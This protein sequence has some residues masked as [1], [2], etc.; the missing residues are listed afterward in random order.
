MTSSYSAWRSVRKAPTSLYL[1]YGKS[2][3]SN[4]S[5]GE[6]RARVTDRLELEIELSHNLRGRNQ[7][8]N[9]VEDARRL[10]AGDLSDLWE[11]QAERVLLT[12]GER[13]AERQSSSADGLWRLRLHLDGEW[14][15]LA[16][17]ASAEGS[18]LI[19]EIVRREQPV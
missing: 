1:R 2:Y 4:L 19:L 5:A 9:T 14:V 8:T 18:G 7:S 3:T 16:R 11:I 10:A 12:S 13:E 17:L 15:F 6:V